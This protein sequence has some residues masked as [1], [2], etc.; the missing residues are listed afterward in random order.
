[1]FDVTSRESFVSLDEWIQTVKENCDK[2]TI[3]LIVGNKTDL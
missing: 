1:M 2:G 3:I